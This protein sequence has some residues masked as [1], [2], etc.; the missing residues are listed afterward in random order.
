LSGFAIF[1]DDPAS[2]LRM[3]G[4]IGPTSLSRA[5]S[6]VPSAH[7]CGF[8]PDVPGS[9]VSTRHLA[10]AHRPPRGIRRSVPLSPAFHSP[11][12]GFAPLGS[13]VWTSA[14]GI[15][16]FA[17]LL[18]PDSSASVF[19]RGGPRVVWRPHPPRWF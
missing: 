19:R 4:P 7:P 11:R 18:R 3:A 14:P 15:Q 1:P 5:D 17:A 10:P 16:P 9:D 8:P 6:R 2:V 12:H 13:T